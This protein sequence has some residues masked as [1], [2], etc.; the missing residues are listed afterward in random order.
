MEDYEE[1]L[2]KDFLPFALVQEL[3]KLNYDGATLFYIDE[4]NTVSTDKTLLSGEI[5]P[6]VL[7]QQAFRWLYTEHSVDC[8]IVPLLDHE[9]YKAEVYKEKSL[10][11]LT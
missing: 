3:E 1:K 2:S 7:Y 6:A 8:I 5:L 10:Q 11:P 4:N 9:T